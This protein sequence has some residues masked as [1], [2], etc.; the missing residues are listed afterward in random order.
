MASGGRLRDTHA[1]VVDRAGTVVGSMLKAL[2]LLAELPRHTVTSSAPRL[3]TSMAQRH[4]VGP[5]TALSPAACMLTELVDGWTYHQLPL[6]ARWVAGAAATGATEGGEVAVEG[7]AARAGGEAAP[8]PSNGTA[9]PVADAATA[10][11]GV[12]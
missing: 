7:A 11:A 5:P 4:D 2:Q 12:G 10:A 3:T 6:P 1:V 9:G 8:T